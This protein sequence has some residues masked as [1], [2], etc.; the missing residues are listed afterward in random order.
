[1]RLLAILTAAA[2]SLA[3]CD[4]ASTPPAASGGSYQ[5]NYE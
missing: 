1:M 4:A 5:S 2:L 3:A